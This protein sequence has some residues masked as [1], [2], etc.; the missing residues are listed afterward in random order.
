MLK[1]GVLN[2]S[3]P[4]EHG[5]V[6]NWDD[7]E[8]ILNY[9]FYTELRVVPEEH[10]ILLTEAPLNPKENKE[11]MTQIMFETFKIPSMNIAIPAV[12][13]LYSEGMITGIVCESGHGLTQ[14]APIYDGF[15]MSKAVTKIM[16]G[17]HDLNQFMSNLLMEKTCKLTS[18]SEMEI[19]R[20]IK[21]KL[22]F[23]AQDYEEALKMS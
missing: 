20:D 8:N 19:V 22:G 18:S 1:R 3:Y 9:T 7:M 17:G 16:I 4:I 23:V 13:S 6:K 21:E 2:I 15:V 12:L 11:K 5:I 14:I 10:P